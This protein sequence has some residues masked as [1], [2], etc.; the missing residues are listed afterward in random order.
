MKNLTLTLDDKTAARIRI[1]AAKSGM[2]V[3]RF[4]SELLNQRMAHARS[5]NEAMRNYFAQKPFK[6]EYIDGRRP[7]RE[8]LHDRTGLR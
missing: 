8:E 5:Y 3:S 1:D 4:V 7:T 2:S 6:F